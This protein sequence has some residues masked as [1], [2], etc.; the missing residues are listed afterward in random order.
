MAV[1]LKAF[2]AYAAPSG[3]AATASRQRAR[4]WSS[5]YTNRGV[6]CSRARLT[7]SHPAISRP[8][9]SRI[10]A[11][12]ES[13]LGGRDVI[14]DSMVPGRAAISKGMH[15]E[16][17]RTQSGASLALRWRWEGDEEERDATGEVAGSTSSQCSSMNFPALVRLFTKYSRHRDAVLFPISEVSLEFGTGCRV[18]RTQYASDAKPRLLVAESDA[19]RRGPAA[20]HFAVVLACFEHVSGFERIDRVLDQL[21]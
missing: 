10:V 11:L 18:P 9:S 14:G 2:V 17:P 8:P 21:A 6:P 1:Q 5:S 16:R 4:M 19:E 20:H 12:S 7:R 3:K 15:D 13:R